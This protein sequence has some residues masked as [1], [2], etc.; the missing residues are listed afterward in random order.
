MLASHVFYFYFLYWLAS[1]PK[2]V[3][4]WL[5]NS[6]INLN[7]EAPQHNYDSLCI[8]CISKKT[9][10]KDKLKREVSY[11]GLHCRCLQNVNLTSRLCSHGGEGAGDPLCCGAAPLWAFSCLQATYRQL[12]LPLGWERVGEWGG[13][14]SGHGPQPLNHPS[15]LQRENTS[16]TMVD[17]YPA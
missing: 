12:M 13:G 10:K 15:G 11:I 8:L 4:N 9:N 17:P 7:M 1:S 2:L 6:P 14:C 5:G 3:K 16:L